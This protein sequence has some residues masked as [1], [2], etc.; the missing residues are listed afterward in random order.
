MLR[1]TVLRL[2]EAYYENARHYCSLHPISL[3]TT[4]VMAKYRM[5]IP[6]NDGLLPERG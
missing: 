2:L 6:K 5:N 1:L 4:A 3:A